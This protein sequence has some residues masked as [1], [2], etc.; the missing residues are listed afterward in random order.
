M[1]K[2]NEAP[3][4]AKNKNSFIQ[5]ALCRLCI[6]SVQD[7]SVD[8]RSYPTIGQVYKHITHNGKRPV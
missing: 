8:Y 5:D 7:E 4:Q 6:F 2:P 3:L 1:H